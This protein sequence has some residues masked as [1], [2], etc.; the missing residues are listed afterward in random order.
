MAV[1]ASPL[2][3]QAEE[4]YRRAQTP[5]DKIAALEEMS[6]LVPKHKASE[7]LQAQIKQKLKVAREES[8]RGGGKGRA[9]QRDRD[10]FVVARQG[11][12]QVALLVRM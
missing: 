1:N 7:K 6:R 4:R 10:P 2:Y 11:A 3:Q 8:Q 5:A 9:A 12:G